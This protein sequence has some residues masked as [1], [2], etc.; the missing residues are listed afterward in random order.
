M[1]KDKTLIKRTANKKKYDLPVEFKTYE[2][3]TFLEERV[4]DYIFQTTSLEILRQEFSKEYLLGDDFDGNQGTEELIKINLY[5][6][7]FRDFY[8]VRSA[9]EVLETLKKI[10]SNKLKYELDLVALEKDGT[11]NYDRK[12]TSKG[13]IGLIMDVKEVKDGRK[14]KFTFLI[15]KAIVQILTTEYTYTV[16]LD[17]LS[18]EMNGIYSY[19]FMK[20]IM[21]FVSNGRKKWTIENFRKELKIPKSFKNNNI[22]KQVIEKILKDFKDSEINLREPIYTYSKPGEGKKTITHIEFRYSLKDKFT[23]DTKKFYYKKFLSEEIEYDMFNELFE[24]DEVKFRFEKVSDK[25]TKLRNVKTKMYLK[26]EDAEEAMEYLWNKREY[27][28]RH[29]DEEEFENNWFY[30]CRAEETIMTNIEYSEQNF[31]LFFNTY[32]QKCKDKEKEKEKYLNKS[33]DKDTAYIEELNLEE[34]NPFLFED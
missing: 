23:L 15:P 33:K 10:E 24:H 5:F 18:K 22:K 2:K 25:K 32:I 30:D 17:T 29:M 1:I 16:L 26:T 8:G 6:E 9:K 19:L 20:E 3:L 4:R 31:E 34:E 28:Y 14:K 21:K 13:E 27:F 12:I 11:L 7:D